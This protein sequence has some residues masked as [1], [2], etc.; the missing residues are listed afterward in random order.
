MWVIPVYVISL[1]RTDVLCI[2]L[3]DDPES[4]ILTTARRLDAQ[5]FPLSQVGIQFVQIG[6]EAGAA[7][8]LQ[9]L[10]DD[11]AAAHGVRVNM[12]LISCLFYNV[13]ISM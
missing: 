11:L 5:H 2:P 8:A 13:L 7:Q 10:D 6:N 3:A 4:V 12:P 9:E 1:S